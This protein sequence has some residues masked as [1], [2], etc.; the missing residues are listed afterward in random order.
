MPITEVV[1][2]QDTDGSVPVLAWLR[3]MD[4]R[5]GRITRKVLACI[6][7]LK[8]KGLELRRPLVDSIGDGL[9]ELRIKL[10]HVNYRVI[11]FYAGRTLA[12]LS[13]AC[14]KESSIPKI[15]LKIALDRKLKYQ[16]DPERHTYYG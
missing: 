8:S 7:E 6:D 5:D 11:F 13:H 16:Q 9:Y 4:R 2:Y 12:V 3:E 1:F 10:G 14:T 15:D